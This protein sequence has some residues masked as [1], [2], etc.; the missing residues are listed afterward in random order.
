MRECQNT[1]LQ[2]ASALYIAYNKGLSFNTMLDLSMVVK[3][4]QE[5]SANKL[6]LL[7]Q[8]KIALESIMFDNQSFTARASWQNF[9]G[10]MTIFARHILSVLENRIAVLEL[11]RS[12][13][14]S[15]SCSPNE[16]R[17]DSKEHR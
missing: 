15:V 7:K 1:K 11:P 5:I 12:P 2:T 4:E 8:I 14:S 3:Q 13:S 6:V 17:I 16:L 9:S 10:T